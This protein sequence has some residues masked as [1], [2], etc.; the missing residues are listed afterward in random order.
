MKYLLVTPQFA[1]NEQGAPTPGGLLQFGRCLA[2]ALASSPSLE[3]LDVWCQ[4]VS[5]RM[6]PTIQDFVHAYAPPNLHRRIRG[7]VRRPLPIASPL[8]ES[9]RHSKSVPVTYTS[10]N[11]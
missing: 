1:Y 2:R 6:Q 10:L 4:V 5:P 7:F 11:Y 9:S 3:S 8:A